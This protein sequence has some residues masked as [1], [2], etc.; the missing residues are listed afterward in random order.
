MVPTPKQEPLLD[1]T[2]VENLPIPE[3]NYLASLEPI[4]PMDAT[5]ISKRAN[6]SGR[7]RRWMVASPLTRR[8]FH[9]R[10]PLRKRHL[11]YNFSNLCHLQTCGTDIAVSSLIENWSKDPSMEVNDALIRDATMMLETA[12]QSDSTVCSEIFCIIDSA[13][14]V[15]EWHPLAMTEK[16]ISLGGTIVQ[17]LEKSDTYIPWLIALCLLPEPTFIFSFP[18]MVYRWFPIFIRMYWNPRI[19]KKEIRV[20]W[21]WLRSCIDGFYSI[22]LI[23]H[24]VISVTRDRNSRLGGGDY[25]G[26]RDSDHLFSRFCIRLNRLSPSTLYSTQPIDA[27]DSV[28]TSSQS[29]RLSR[30]SNC[31]RL[32][33]L[34]P[35]ARLSRSSL[36]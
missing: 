19:Q 18:L 36:F 24:T 21:L 1:S 33:R 2:Q 23:D 10:N 11:R 35:C 22:K 20:V 32:S 29:L 15:P 7:K 30:L 25:Y 12:A 4:S 16:I 13:G 28:Q 6:K 8:K 26:T 17:L 34:S 27:L 14:P 3:Y 31:I 9:Y 5:P